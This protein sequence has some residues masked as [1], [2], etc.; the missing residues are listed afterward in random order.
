MQPSEELPGYRQIIF[1]PQVVDDLDFVRYSNRTPYGK[2]GIEWRNSTQGL[3]IKVT[4][5]AG[6]TALVY[7]PIPENQDSDILESGQL[8]LA[9][10]EHVTP[11]GTSGNYHVFSVRS[12]NYYFSYSKG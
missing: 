2:A 12:G 7:V 6:S 4:V 8:L 5:P 11:V 1:K 3:E 10:T 9:D